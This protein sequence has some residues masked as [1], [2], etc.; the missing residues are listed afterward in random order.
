MRRAGARRCFI[1]EALYRISLLYASVHIYSLFRR[2]VERRRYNRFKGSTAI[3]VIKLSFLFRL[4]M[5][6]CFVS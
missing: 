1:T 6:P 4:I 3:E 2:V 5:A